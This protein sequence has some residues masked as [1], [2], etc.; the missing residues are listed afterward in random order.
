VHDEHRDI[1]RG[2][3][4]SHEVAH[5]GGARVVREGDRPAGPPV[6]RLELAAQ[7]VR[8][9]ADS[10]IDRPVP[11]FYQAIGVAAEQGSTVAIASDSKY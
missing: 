10:L 5:D 7:R 1:V 9:K 2:V 6:T 8:E 3:G 11:P 4:V